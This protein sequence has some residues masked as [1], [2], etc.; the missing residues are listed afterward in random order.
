MCASLCAQYSQDF[1]KFGDE[2]FVKLGATVI[3]VEMQSGKSG[4]CTASVHL[5]GAQVLSI[6]A[7]GSWSHS[8]QAAA[9]LDTFPCLRYWMCL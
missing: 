7:A 4:N 5:A 9:G 6:V 2:I 1:G 3:Q 8:L